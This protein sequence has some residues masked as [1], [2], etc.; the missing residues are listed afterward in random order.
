MKLSLVNS[1]SVGLLAAALTLPTA[2]AGT[3]SGN[4]GGDQGQQ[5]GGDQGQQQGGDQGQQAGNEPGSSGNSGSGQVEQQTP[6]SLALLAIL[7]TD[8]AEVKAAA[9]ALTKHPSK[10]TAA[11]ALKLIKERA[12][13]K[14]KGL[15]VAIGEKVD[16]LSVPAELVE[17]KTK[18]DGVVDLIKNTPDEQIDSVFAVQISQLEA[19]LLQNLDG[20]NTA[21]LTDAK[22]KDFV[23]ETY[24][25]L[26]ADQEQGDEGS[27]TN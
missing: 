8:S 3:S 21:G 2:Y 22:I 11:A 12:A 6:D 16:V 20:F 27:T 9:A 17:W 5:Q 14:V 23:D 13:N 4:Q 10:D 19:D 24:S 15:A 1:V 7:Y 26:K 18:A 25:S